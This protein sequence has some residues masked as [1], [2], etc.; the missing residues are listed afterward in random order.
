MTKTMI[1]QIPIGFT[2]KHR[3]MIEELKQYVNTGGS[4]PTMSVV[5]RCAVEELY[6]N[7][8]K[9]NVRQ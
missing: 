1:K 6:K 4:L 2:D 8:V 7:K 9:K 5:V 3:E